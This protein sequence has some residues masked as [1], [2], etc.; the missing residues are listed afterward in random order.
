M[1]SHFL[2]NEMTIQFSVQSLLKALQQKIEEEQGEIDDEEEKIKELETLIQGWEGRIEKVEE[3]VGEISVK[4]EELEGMI[5][6]W[7]GRIEAMEGK[8]DAMETE[9]S[10]LN[11]K[12]DNLE[13]R[14][15]FSQQET[16]A[17]L[18]SSYFTGIDCLKCK[19]ADGLVYVYFYG[20]ITSIQSIPT[21]TNCGTVAAK[22]MTTSA[23]PDTTLMDEQGNTLGSFQV[24]SDRSIK[25]IGTKSIPTNTHILL[26]S[27]AYPL[28]S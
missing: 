24:Q 2:R 25:F 28:S 26:L 11:T 13:E 17:T 4:I 23:I 12:V 3:E 21:G 19:T 1:E 18:N 20:T 7:E 15:P 5:V 27:I 14:V 16:W 10:G 6:G 22:W 8:V 9:L